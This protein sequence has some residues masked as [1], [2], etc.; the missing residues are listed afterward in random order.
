MR[1][2][3]VIMRQIMR[4]FPADFT[5]NL[6]IWVNFRQ[7][8]QEIHCV[9]RWDQDSR[10]KATILQQTI[11]WNI[12]MILSGQHS[13]HC[14]RNAPMRIH[15]RINSVPDP[16]R[17]KQCKNAWTFSFEWRSFLVLSCDVL[18]SKLPWNCHKVVPFLLTHIVLFV[19]I[20][21]DCAEICELCDRMWFLINCA[22]S[23]HRTISEALTELWSFMGAGQVWAK[24]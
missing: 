16:W 2:F 13:I 6:S 24:I 11:T 5:K 7:K 8:R 19:R 4:F 1:Q 21:R 17:V 12:S 18:G 10:K 14:F 23:H 15:F 3:R 22:G 20:M 9:S